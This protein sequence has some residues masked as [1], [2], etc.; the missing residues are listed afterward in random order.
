[1]QEL[2]P[3]TTLQGGKYRILSV[4]GQGGYGITYKAQQSGLNRTVAIK[5]FFVS[6]LCDRNTTRSTMVAVSES[7][8]EHV[9]RYRKK[10]ASE[11]QMISNLHHPNIISIYE[12]FNE[13]GSSYYVMEYIEGGSLTDLI[14]H[15]AV[16]EA[17][18]LKYIRPVADALRYIHKQ[19]ICHYDIKPNNIMVRKDNGQPVLIDFGISKHYDEKDKA[20]TTTPVGISEGYA[21]LEQYNPKNMAKFS[22]QTDIYS[23]GATLLALVTGHTPPAPSVIISNGLPIPGHLSESTQNAIRHAMVLN[24]ETRTATIDQFLA[25]LGGTEDLHED[26]RVRPINDDSTTAAASVA[27]SP[28]T[29][30]RG[31]TGSDAETDNEEEDP[32][33]KRL[34]IVASILGVIVGSLLLF[35]ILRAMSNKDEVQ[36]A[37][38][39][40]EVS[41]AEASTVEAPAT[42][43]EKVEPI[44]QPETVYDWTGTYTAETDLGSTAGG[45]PMIMMIEMVLNK[46]G[47]EYSGTMSIDGYQTMGRYHITANASTNNLRVYCKSTDADSFGGAQLSNGDNI[48]TLT[49]GNDR[50]LT[51]SWS[52]YMEDVTNDHTTISKK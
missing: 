17:E 15:G 44:A 4:L 41:A 7:N 52:H 35:I 40:T 45:T 37:E 51:V 24:R 48:C 25:Q 6:S 23:L 8:V 31:Y 14:K 49:Y 39:A 30:A 29:A 38:S 9:E 28:I 12:V 42:I 34:I 22:P 11:A 47:D 2:Q 20:S 43:E 10:F 36:Y 5:E 21:P 16:S 3:G 50:T 13:N 18:A 46:N 33:R 32:N 26:T 19:K 27:A 1:M